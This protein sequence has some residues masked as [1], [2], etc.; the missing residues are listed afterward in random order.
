MTTEAIR[1]A[2]PGRATLEILREITRG[3]LAGLV[4]G[5][6]VAGVGGR[7]V[8]RL[9]ALLVPAADGA[10]T[11]NGNRIGDITV[12]GTVTLLVLGLFFGVVA[13]S[14][15]VT[16]R[17]FLPRSMPAR[18]ALSLPVAVALGTTILIEPS[19]SDFAILGRDPLVVASLV[20]LVALVGP[21]L[22]LADA[23]LDGRLPRPRSTD[24]RTIWVYTA[25][26]LVGLLIFGLVV[27]PA[28]FAAPRFPLGVVLATIGVATLATWSARI[29][30]D[31]PLPTWPM[32]VGRIGI[33]AIVLVGIVIVVPDLLRVLGLR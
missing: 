19:N 1:P 29:R 4:V 31:T 20:V 22:V 32:V 8:M 23:W 21:G 33:A 10:F 17:A 27:V 14:L 2:P 9:A 26:L 18:V 7:L 24:R 30:G 3:G 5:V 25:L 6:L 13:G 11:E 12:G 16:I 15:W 28:Y